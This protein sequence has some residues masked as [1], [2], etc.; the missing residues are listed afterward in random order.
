MGE[1][2]PRGTRSKGEENVEGGEEKYVVVVKHP[3]AGGKVKNAWGE[4][5][6]RRV[7]NL[8]MRCEWRFFKLP[9]KQG[10]TKGS[11]T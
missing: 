11:F 2:M 7:N 3:P 6:M 8:A 4:V 9:L 1:E 5:K 10:F